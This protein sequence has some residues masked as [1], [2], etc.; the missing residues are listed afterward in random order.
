MAATS[1]QFCICARP[2]FRPD[3]DGKPVCLICSKAQRGT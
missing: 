2:Q 3:E 1:R